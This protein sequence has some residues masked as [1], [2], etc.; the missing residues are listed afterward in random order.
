MAIRRG[1]LS[2]TARKGRSW[3]SS[4]KSLD[5]KTCALPATVLLGFPVQEFREAPGEYDLVSPPQLG[6]SGGGE[7]GD[8][9]QRDVEVAI[10]QAWRQGRRGGEPCKRG[11]ALWSRA[12]PDPACP[13]SQPRAHPP[14][15]R[16]G[17][18]PKLPRHGSKA[19]SARA[20]LWFTLPQQPFSCPLGS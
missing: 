2:H 6:S 19:Q 16:T 10:K 14:A 11:L 15:S 9:G 8:L 4:P 13:P 7:G 17:L 3:D 1:V 20:R 5:S 18:G 12:H